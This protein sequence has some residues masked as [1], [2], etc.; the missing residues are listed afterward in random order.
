MRHQPMK[1]MQSDVDLGE[2]EQPEDLGDPTQVK[3]RNRRVAI[4]QRE[5]ADTLVQIMGTKQGRAWMRHLV[6]DKL[7]YDKKI[8]TGNSGTFA[9]AGMLEVAQTLTR[10]LKTLCFDQWA[11]M[12]REA[13]E[14]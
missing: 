12:E 7:C 10:E 13:M 6:Y 11:A 5:L 3:E 14:K 1:Q 4:R 8:F 2:R 9:N